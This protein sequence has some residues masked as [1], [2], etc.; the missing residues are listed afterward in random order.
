MIQQDM[1]AT[2]RQDF[3][4]GASHRVR[5]DGLTPAILYGGSDKSVALSLDEK[6]LTRSLLQ[7]QGKNAVVS[8]H[9]E[10]EKGKKV[11]HVLV[12]EIQK[13]PV[14]DTL[15]HVD[16]F[17]ISLDK[18][19][20]L[21]VLVN[22]NGTAIGVDL[23]GVMNISAQTVK[24]KGLPLDIP[25]SIELDV[26]SLELGGP[27]FS[28]KDLSIPENVSLE[29]DPE[30]TCVAVVAPKAVVEEVEEEELEGEE[31]EEGGEEGEKAAPAAEE[32]EASSE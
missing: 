7:L 28:C 25:D 27:G 29:E 11:H 5:Q 14:S 30:R 4:K 22:Y 32:S 1:T 9:I 16:F 15:I 3:G 18:E 2:I 26:T 8:L 17:E 13:N 6:S 12:K 19:I 31:G 20:T 21:A 23:G 10:G 24:I